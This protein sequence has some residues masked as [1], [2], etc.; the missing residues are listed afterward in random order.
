MNMRRRAYPYGRYLIKDKE[1]SDLGLKLKD[2]V[3][4]LGFSIVKYDEKNEGAGTFII[5]V[6]KKIGDL[7]KQKKPFGHFQE[8]I[9][10]LS[11][12]F[13]I[14]ITSFRYTDEKSQRI[15]IEIY[16]WPIDKGILMEMFVLPYMEYL[17]KTEIYGITETGEEEITDWF[18]CEQI[19]EH[20]EPKIVDNFNAEPVHMRA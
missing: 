15:G 7:F 18:L 5:C 8:I 4:K 9:Y 20:V 19:W 2:F 6:N 13:S 1:I 14:D 10:E 3:E 17:N 12:L 16:L 11:S